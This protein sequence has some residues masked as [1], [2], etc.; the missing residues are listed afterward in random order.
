MFFRKK[1]MSS[2][3]E[4]DCKTHKYIERETEYKLYKHIQEQLN[5]DNFIPRNFYELRNY[6]YYGYIN[7]LLR[8]KFWKLLL[9][10]LPKN[11]F[12][13]EYHLKERRKL[14]HFYLEK[15][16][17][18]LCE[19]PGI[20]DTINKDIDR[21]CIKPINNCEEEELN[22]QKIQNHQ[23]VED[24]SK[25]DEKLSIEQNSSENATK[26]DE[27][28]LVDGQNEFLSFDAKIISK[29]CQ[30]LDSSENVIHRNALKR[31]L[32]TYKVTN[33]SI[34]YTQ[35]MHMVLMP[36]Y[37][38]FATSDDL[39]DVKYAEED[40]FFCFFNLLS[41]IG[42]NFIEEYDN[43]CRVGIKKK[44][45]MI[46]DLVKQNDPELFEELQKKELTKTLFAFKWISLLL[47][48]E[49]EID[50]LIILWDKFFSDSYRFEILIYC[51]AA[52]IILMKKAILQCEFEECMK[53][54]QV[55]KKIDALTVFTL[56]DKMRRDNAN[57]QK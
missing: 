50:Q 2:I 27:N 34:G 37:Y 17:S 39:E 13:T 11:K 12:K 40:A 4:D 53:I 6:C 1:E 45:E 28:H 32:L 52:I 5:I 49:F 56:A 35:G 36:I 3:Q 20:D 18:I 38:V 51:C 57:Q 9:C 44:I 14:Y 25:L 43:D 21:M 54:L 23:H 41:E 29:K 48:S 19:S 15:S 46:Y 30:F 7:D 10:Y 22:E 26:D 24:E 55:N 47:C 31:I 16:M 42:E 8:P 33:S